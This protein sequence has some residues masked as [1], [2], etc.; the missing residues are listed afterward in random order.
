MIF[1]NSLPSWPNLSIIDLMCLC[2]RPAT[3]RFSVS[4]LR[5]SRQEDSLQSQEVDV[6]VATQ[7]CTYRSC[8]NKPVP[9]PV[10]YW[11]PL[12]NCKNAAQTGGG[13]GESY[14]FT[15][16]QT[17]EIISDTLFTVDSFTY[18]TALQSSLFSVEH[19]IHRKGT[20]CPL[21]ELLENCIAAVD[22]QYPG[23]HQLIFNF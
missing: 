14:Y 2:C 11:W 6:T 17:Q 1:F 13:E 22:F 15:F 23:I 8:Q 3:F 7:W 18:V 12:G 20:H 21:L 19:S 10:H 9:P 16:C 4:R 5:R